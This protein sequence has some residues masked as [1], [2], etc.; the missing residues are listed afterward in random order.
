M[1]DL[2]RVRLTDAEDMAAALAAAV[3]DNR[4]AAGR[5]D[6]PHIVRAA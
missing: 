3:I 6:P 1:P 5:F 2:I 4:I